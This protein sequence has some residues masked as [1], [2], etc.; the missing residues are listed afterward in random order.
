VSKPIIK[1]SVIEYVLQSCRRERTL[2]HIA[3][4]EQTSTACRYLSKHGRV[5]Q[6][7][8]LESFMREEC[9][10]GFGD[11]FGKEL[12]GSEQQDFTLRKVEYTIAYN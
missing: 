7:L 1:R 12:Q 6:G 5:G 8:Y 9:S 4:I 10:Y 3:F 11:D 2:L